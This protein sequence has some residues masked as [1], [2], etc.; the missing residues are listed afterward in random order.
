VFLTGA[1]LASDKVIK[2]CFRF[3][4]IIYLLGKTAGLPDHNLWMAEMAC[5]AMALTANQL[6]YELL[7]VPQFAVPAPRQ[8][9]V[10]AGSFFHYYCDINDGFGG[11]FADSEWNKQLFVARDFLAEDLESF[12]RDARGEVERRF[13]DLALTARRR[14]LESPAG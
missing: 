14:L 13:L 4:Q 9:T 5:F 2:D 1:T 3:A 10:P 6:D 11:P 12:R 7:D 8:A